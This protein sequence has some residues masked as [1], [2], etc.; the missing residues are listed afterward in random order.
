MPVESVGEGAVTLCVLCV[1]V[2]VAGHV[3]LPRGGSG[4]GQRTFR[5]KASGGG[6]AARHDH[7]LLRDKTRGRGCRYA[8]KQRVLSCIT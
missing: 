5:A 4:A 3:H 6:G 1:G 2:S 7:E 8:S